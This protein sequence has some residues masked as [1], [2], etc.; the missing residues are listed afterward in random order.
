MEK[1]IIFVIISWTCFISLVLYAFTVTDL[2][3]YDLTH[4]Q[5][6]ALS[7][8][9]ENATI[10]E[11]TINTINKFSVLVNVSTAWQFLTFITFIYTLAFIVALALLINEFIPFT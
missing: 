9:Q 11:N 10:I 8:N 3:I 6:Q 5:E 7:I 1:W 4:E 2:N